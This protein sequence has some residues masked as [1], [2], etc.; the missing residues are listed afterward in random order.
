M[1]HTTTRELLNHVLDV[2]EETMLAFESEVRLGNTFALVEQSHGKWAGVV[3]RV[4]IL[5]T[6]YQGYTFCNLR[7]FAG[8]GKWRDEIGDRTKWCDTCLS[9]AY[10]RV[11]G[12]EWQRDLKVV[13]K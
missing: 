13:I 9:L 12:R 2:D 5:R 4:H 7:P 3:A 8:A 11:H 1:S 6:P 10:H